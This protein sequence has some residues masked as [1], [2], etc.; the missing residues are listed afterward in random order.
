MGSLRGPVVR[1]FVCLSLM[2]AGGC[3]TPEFRQPLKPEVFRSQQ[4]YNAE[5]VLLPGDQIE[6]AVFRVPDA[7]KS[8]AVRPDG[9]ISLPGLKD[10]QVGGLTVPQAT[11]K[12]T[13]LLKERLV[14]PDVTLTVLNPRDASVFVLGE[15]ARPGPLPYRT[16][17]NAATALAQAG[18][19]IR[20]A[21]L[22]GVAVLRLGDD[23]YL[24]ATVIERKNGGVTGFYA[25]LQQVLM[26]P[27]DILIIPESGRSQFTRF[28]QDFV[29]T[30][31]SG[32]N[33]VL[34]P[35]LQLRVIRAIKR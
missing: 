15:V 10:V 8:V 25:A 34:S 27:N 33:Q 7:S 4:R 30:P 22:R 16:T 12:I 20:S 5:Y 19:P 32:A 13:D 18:G 21:A 11:E 35:Y 1:A 6:V 17:S 2:A 24:T 26:K 3:T 9:A 14:A 28:I 31:L 23:G 29:N